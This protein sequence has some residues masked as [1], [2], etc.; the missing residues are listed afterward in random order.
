MKPN[1]TEATERAGKALHKYRY[2]LIVILA[3]LLL[4]LWP[5]GSSPPPAAIED[6]VPFSLEEM[7]RKLAQTLSEIDGA[8]RVEVMLTLKSDME[9]VVI[10]DINARSH[11]EMEDGSAKVTDSEQQSKTV[12]T[13]AGNTPFVTKRVYPH[14]QGALIVCDGAGSAQV[15]MAVLNAVTSLTGLRS[16]SVSVVKRKS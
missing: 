12:L 2:L 8:G 9:V 3:G 15:Q 14:F 7:E 11:T 5:K 16:E 1:L 6:A 10:Q 13:N 4:L